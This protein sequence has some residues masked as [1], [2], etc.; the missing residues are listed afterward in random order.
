MH[1]C[2]CICDVVQKTGSELRRNSD[3]LKVLKGQLNWI[4][5]GKMRQS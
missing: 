1:L 5:H 4:F 2:Y 3:R